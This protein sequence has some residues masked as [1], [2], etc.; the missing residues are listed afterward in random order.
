MTRI[1][2]SRRSILAAS[3]GALAA[4]AHAPGASDEALVWEHKMISSG[5]NFPDFRSG[6]PINTE[7][8]V[9]LHQRRTPPRS[10][11]ADAALA[12]LE[13]KD[14]V[15]RRGDVLRPSVFVA[16]PD[17]ARW[18]A[19]S[20]ALVRDSVSVIV[21]ALPAVRMRVQTIGNLGAIPFECSGFFLV[22]DVLLDNWQINAVEEGV[23]GVER[24]QRGGGRYYYA[25]MARRA[26]SD[27]EPFGIYGNQ[28]YGYDGFVVGVYGN[29]RVT[30]P[31]LPALSDADLA[32][33]FGAG[34]DSA[35]LARRLAQAAR[36]ESVLSSAEIA[37]FRSLDLVDVQGR[38]IAPVLSEADSEALDGVAGLV[39]APL[40]ARLNA[41]KEAL[42]RLHAR[43][44]YAQETTFEEYF[45]WWYHVYYT[46]VTDALI[47]AG[48]AAPPRAGIVTYVVL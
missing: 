36:R 28:T 18:L 24:P 39:R 14:F 30:A 17:D 11:E 34:A 46:Q 2:F 22:S 42:R 43:S 8:L 38:V 12:L 23:L 5:G 16:G 13:E 10:P 48:A 26:D 41:E 31:S 7:I 9:A 19:V 27:E 44:P 35:A 29:K 1:D 15:T 32:A 33:R 47:A 21:A 3:G 40:I 4:C 37:G 6:A 20:D 45:M 25:V